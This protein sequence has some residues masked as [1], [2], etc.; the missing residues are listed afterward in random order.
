MSISTHPA[1]LETFDEPQAAQ[2]DFVFSFIISN[3]PIEKDRLF[4]ILQ[5][6]HYK[7]LINLVTTF[8]PVT[9]NRSPLIK[10]KDYCGEKPLFAVH[11]ILEG[12]YLA[13]FDGG[14][15]LSRH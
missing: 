13:E 2:T 5:V 7:I 9:S 3:S 1:S 11:C 4:L 8:Q 15:A 10:D 14:R 6:F 12:S